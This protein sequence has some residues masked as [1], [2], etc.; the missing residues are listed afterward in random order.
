[1]GMIQYYLRADDAKVKEIQEGDSVFHSSSDDDKM[2]D[3]DK[4]WHAI[5]FTL[6]GEVWELD[7]DN[8]LG[9]LVLGGEPINDDDMGYGPA[10]L[11]TKDIVVLLADELE[12]WEEADFRE[13]FDLKAMIENKV[14]PVMDEEEEEQFFE[15]VWFY[16]KEVKKFF[17]QAADQ[18]EN[19]ISV[20]C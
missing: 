2:L 12:N 4:A 11:L 17:R 1:M 10:R 13:K 6:T 9:Q 8:F 3:I 18:G 5:H 16:F 14:Y 19:V 7:E 20:V 15:Y